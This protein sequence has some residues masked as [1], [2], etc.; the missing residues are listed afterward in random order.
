M[1]KSEKK[2]RKNLLQKIFS[3][4]DKSEDPKHIVDF[5]DSGTVEEEDEIKP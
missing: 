2:P 3:S 4:K 1:S 5:H